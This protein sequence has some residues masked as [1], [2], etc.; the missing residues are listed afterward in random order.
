MS[1]SR[2][3]PNVLSHIGSYVPASTRAALATTTKTARSAFA[4]LPY[5]RD[6]PRYFFKLK[7]E[8]FF[9]FCDSYNLVFGQ[10]LDGTRYLYQT[11]PKATLYKSTDAQIHALMQWHLKETDPRTDCH[12]LAYFKE[13]IKL[14]MAA[15]IKKSASQPRCG[16]VF[17]QK[18]GLG[19]VGPGDGLRASTALVCATARR[20]SL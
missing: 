14:E 7:S 11:G 13:M 16:V 20:H 12:L 18:T 9:V 4:K 1:F 15:N 6:K 10:V 5:G 2:Q 19:Y 3:P 17:I 8:G